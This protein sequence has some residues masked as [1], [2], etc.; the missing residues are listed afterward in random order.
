MK[1]LN[2]HI[3]CSIVTRKSGYDPVMNELV[4]FLILPLDLGLNPSKD[5]PFH[6][7]ITPQSEEGKLRKNYREYLTK[8]GLHPDLLITTF[9]NWYQKLQL[10]HNKRIIPLAYN[11]PEQLI[12]LRNWFGYTAD[13][14]PHMFDF[15]HEK[16]YRDLFPVSR[17]W[18]D[19]LYMNEEYTPFTKLEFLPICSKLGVPHP[20]DATLLSEAI[21]LAKAYQKISNLSIPPG[22]T[23]DLHFPDPIDYEES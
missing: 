16:E 22:V 4:E 1:H 19:L 5:L 9:E 11:W 17:Y 14:F 10:R 6:G 3:L 20:K 21:A 18:N 23:L 15:F 2:N 8:Y 12:F 13:G 7:V